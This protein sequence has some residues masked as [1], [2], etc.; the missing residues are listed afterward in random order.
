MTDALDLPDKHIHP[1]RPPQAAPGLVEATGSAD[2]LVRCMLDAG[3]RLNKLRMVFDRHDATREQLQAAG[4]ATA[5]ML[6]ELDT[7]LHSTSL[8]VLELLHAHHPAPT[9]T[10]PRPP[11]RPR[12]R[13][14]AG[15]LRPAGE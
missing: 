1:I 2:K 8:A 3:L 13:G 12:T 4:A 5:D 7:L 15:P 10:R 11:R 9:D 14:K 6:D